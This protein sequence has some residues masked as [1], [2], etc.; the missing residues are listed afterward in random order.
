MKLIEVEGRFEC[1]NCG[2]ITSRS[3]LVSLESLEKDKAQMDL[4]NKLK[5][6]CKANNWKPIRIEVRKNG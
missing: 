4:C 6:A 2:G 1:V 5:C 3:M